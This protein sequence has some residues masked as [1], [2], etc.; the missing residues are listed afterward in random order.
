MYRFSPVF[1]SVVVAKIV[2]LIFFLKP[3]NLMISIAQ[4]A[5]NPPQHVSRDAKEMKLY[6]WY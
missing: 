2:N 6:F 5:L 3:V 1:P 4:P